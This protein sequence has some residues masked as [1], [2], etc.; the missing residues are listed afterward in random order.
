MTGTAN[1]YPENKT[2]ADCAAI[3]SHFYYT[4]RYHQLFIHVCIDPFHPCN[5][6]VSSGWV[7]G[8]GGGTG[9]LFD[10][11]TILHAHYAVSECKS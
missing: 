1:N 8:T 2:E 11:V 6:R 3:L 5:R 7:T 4:K 9:L 10:L